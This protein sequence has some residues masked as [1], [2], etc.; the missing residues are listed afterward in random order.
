ML[1][2]FSF[3]Q[4]VCTNF[5]CSRRSAR[6]VG[7]LE[8]FGFPYTSFTGLYPGSCL[9]NPKINLFN[10]SMIRPEEAEVGSIGKRTTGTS[11]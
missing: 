11:K 5:P 8:V 2:Y 9:C 7:I 6:R 3:Q 1:C 10:V 4:G